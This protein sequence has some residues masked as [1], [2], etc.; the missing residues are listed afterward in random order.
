MK[1]NLLTDI[2]VAEMIGR[3]EK[4]GIERVIGCIA[5]TPVDT[6]MGM[7]CLAARGLLSL[8]LPAA[9]TPEE[10][11][12]LQILA[13]AELTARVETLIGELRGLGADGIFLYC[14]SMS[15]AIDLPYLRR[16]TGLKIVTPLDVYRELARDYTRLGVMAANNQS[17]AGIERT[18]QASNP[19]CWPIGF[20]QLPVV[21]DIENGRPPREIVAGYKLAGVL[22]AMREFGSEVLLLGCTHF[23]Y[24]K[25]ELQALNILPVID[26]A[27][28]MIE[29]LLDGKPD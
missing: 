11:S 1:A 14:N 29:I 12:L 28:R 21:I 18:L 4:G 26:P 2:P 27:D 20:A 22:E 10:Q 17:L 15:G 7:D 6:R 3:K 25:E 16:Q 13:P 5:G 24:L 8:G 9:A 23:P 19:A